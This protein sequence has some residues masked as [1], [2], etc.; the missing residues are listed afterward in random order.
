MKNSVCRADGRVVGLRAVLALGMAALLVGGCSK[1]VKDQVCFQSA[2]YDVEVV[3]DGR[4]RMRG[5][6]G[7][8]ELGKQA[9]MLFIFQ[10]SWPF[11]FWMKDTL[12]P[13]DMIWLDAVR[14]VVY[15]EHDVPPCQADPCPNYGPSQAALYVLELNAGE[16]ARLGLKAGDQMVFHLDKYLGK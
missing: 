13:L 2:C 3:A 15:V 16:T 4:S 12:I 6:Q 14:K 11:R 5:L 10:E 9:G 7:R 1:D 8:T